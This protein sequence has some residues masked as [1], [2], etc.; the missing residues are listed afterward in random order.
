MPGGLHRSAKTGRAAYAAPRKTGI[1]LT[2]LRY[3]R[4]GG[5][6]D[7]ERSRYIIDSQIYRIA[8][9]A[10][11]ISSRGSLILASSPLRQNLLAFCVVIS[12]IMMFNLMN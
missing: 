2:L 12:E 10:F 9:R 8:R 1:G 3:K 7:A 11:T 6:G 4:P 5:E